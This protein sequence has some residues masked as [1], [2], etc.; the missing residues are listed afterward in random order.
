[1]T[2]LVGGALFRERIAPR[3]GCET[4]MG[5]EDRAARLEGRPCERHGGRT[6][7]MPS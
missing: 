7:P 4:D 6:V 2:R 1:M 3:Y 5:V